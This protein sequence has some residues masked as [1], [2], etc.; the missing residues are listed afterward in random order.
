[1]VW[2]SS[3]RVVV[4]TESSEYLIGGERKGGVECELR[5]KGKQELR[6]CEL[7]QKI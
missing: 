2:A 6:T 4:A 3:E 1:M 5:L 7:S